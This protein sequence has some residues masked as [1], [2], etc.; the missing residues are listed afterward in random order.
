M[1]KIET[2]ETKEFSQCVIQS[3]SLVGEIVSFSFRYSSYADTYTDFDEDG[4]NLG[5]AATK[6]DLAKWEVE[7]S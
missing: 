5:T 7:D 6:I 1:G 3:F 2:L 4:S